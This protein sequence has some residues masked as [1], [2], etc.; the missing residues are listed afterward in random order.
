VPYPDLSRP[1]DLKGLKLATG[2]SQ[3]DWEPAFRSEG[4]IDLRFHDLGD[5]HQVLAR[6][7]A[8]ARELVA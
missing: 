4:E 1:L 5:G 6:P 3:A 7:D 2:A 8:R